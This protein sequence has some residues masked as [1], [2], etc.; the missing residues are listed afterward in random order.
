MNSLISVIVPVYNIEKYIDKCVSSIVE[1]T[2]KNL[3]I[4]LIDDG[5]SDSSPQ[6]CDEW[7]KRDSRIKVIHKINGGVS[8]AR[9]VGL[10]IASG[11]YIGFAD[12]DDYLSLEQFEKVAKVID[13]HDP[14][15]VTFDWYRVK[16]NGEII[17]STEKITECC[18]DPETAVRELLKGNI[19]NYMWNKVF[20]RNVFDGI[21]F[22]ENR[23][24]EDAA[25]C[26]K[27]LLATKKIYCYPE[28]MYFYLLRK[29][30]IS[31]SGI[32]DKTL[33]DIFLARYECYLYLSESYPDLLDVITPKAATIAIRLFD[34]SLWSDVEQD[35]LNVA[36]RFLMENKED[37]L[38]YTDDSI[39]K[40]YY[41]APK[42]YALFRIL[43]H[44]IGNIVK[45]IKK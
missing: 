39:F 13:E 43:R 18:I 41:G 28:K 15:V 32:S 17:P 12:G 8:T 10:D 2:Y 45:K 9:N 7:A 35:T 38:K 16:E 14:D 1:Q 30:S 42:I 44:K 3:E 19:N 29:G 37:I 24:W 26:Y 4:I 21:R 25:I 22:P 11:D 5:S 33:R 31:K 20:K 34:R 36:K 23:V 40:L 6:K 27:L